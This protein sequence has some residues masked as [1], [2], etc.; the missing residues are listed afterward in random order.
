MGQEGPAGKLP[1]PCQVGSGQTKG[2]GLGPKGHSAPSLPP[3][4]LEGGP[5][6]EHGELGAPQAGT[7]SGVAKPVGLGQDGT[8]QGSPALRLP[9]P[10]QGKQPTG[11]Q[12]QPDPLRT[13]TC[14]GETQSQQEHRI[15]VG[16]PQSP[17]LDLV[18]PQHTRGSS[19]GTAGL[20]T[21]GTDTTKGRAKSQQ[22]IRNARRQLQ[23]K[24]Q[25]ALLASSAHGAGMR[26]KPWGRSHSKKLESIP[27]EQ[28]E[29]VEGGEQATPA[30]SLSP[31]PPQTPVVAQVS[32]QG[33]GQAYQVQLKLDLDV[34][35]D[36]G[37][38]LSLH[39]FDRLS[40]TV[41]TG[42]APPVVL[43]PTGSA[44]Q[45][46]GRVRKAFKEVIHPGLQN[47]RL[48]PEIF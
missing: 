16:G 43:P 46:N 32:T 10:T 5:G 12:G 21:K 11:E 42:D 25:S 39:L 37:V 29:G 23:G 18:P 26:P 28:A 36:G 8:T 48:R 9:A 30:V 7:L 45:K 22:G 31:A 6:G 13:G 34:Q 38:K 41:H 4:Q 35:E 24:L 27:E 2:V 17:I 19:E 33:V 15:G 20:G 47:W 44:C 14:R 3:P 1:T 40:H